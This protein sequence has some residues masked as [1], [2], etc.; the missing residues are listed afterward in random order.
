MCLRWPCSHIISSVSY[1]SLVSCYLIYITTVQCKVYANY[2]LHN[3]PTDV[4]PCCTLQHLIFI[5]MRIVWKHHKFVRCILSNVRLRRSVFSKWSFM[6]YI[7]L[8]GISK[9]TSFLW[10]KIFV[11]HFIVVIKSQIWIFSH[12]SGLAHGTVHAQCLVMFLADSLWQ[13]IH[14]FLTT[15]HFLRSDTFFLLWGYIYHIIDQ[16]TFSVSRITA[17]WSFVTSHA[18]VYFSMDTYMTIYGRH[19]SSIFHALEENVCRI[20]VILFTPECIKPTCLTICA[21]I[22]IH[23]G[24]AVTVDRVCAGARILT[25]ITVTFISICTNTLKWSLCPKMG[26][27]SEG[28]RDDAIHKVWV[29]EWVSEWVSEQASEWVNEWMSRW[30]S[31]TAFFSDIGDRGPCN[32]YKLC[33]HDLYI[34]IITFPHIDNTIYRLQ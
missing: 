14:F 7:E 15:K 6:Q 17:F 9:P 34:G 2:R 11:L 13:L 27:K 33:N 21:F 28:A 12:Y 5:I 26:V 16:I 10:Q 22:P 29:C 24:A 8:C 31:L 19:S 30:V 18:L 20:S 25:G 32:T 1:I 3:G 4:F 23:T